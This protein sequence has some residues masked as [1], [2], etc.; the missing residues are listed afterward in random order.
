MKHQTDSSPS[1]SQLLLLPPFLPFLPYPVPAS[2]SHRGVL[3]HFL[4][5][6]LSV[7]E[8]IFLVS[9]REETR[10]APARVNPI[11]VL[12]AERLQFSGPQ[13]RG[14]G[15]RPCSQG[16]LVGSKKHLQTLYRYTEAG[17]KG[18]IRGTT[19]LGSLVVFCSLFSFCSF[20]KSRLTYFIKT[21]QYVYLSDLEVCQSTLF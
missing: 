10:P 16:A 12:S 20:K 13:V 11:G 21:D 4:Q 19:Q 9:R 7:T 17:R 14:Y 5:A 3:N 6:I 1:W 18:Q 2:W 8:Y 15:A